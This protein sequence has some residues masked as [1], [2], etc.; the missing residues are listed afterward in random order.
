MFDLEKNYSTRKFL[1]LTWLLTERLTFCFE[2]YKKAFW[3]KSLLNVLTFFDLPGNSICLK[4]SFWSFDIFW[5]PRK[6]N[7][8]EEISSFLSSNFGGSW[9]EVLC[10]NVTGWIL[11]LPL[12]KHSEMLGS[13][14]LVLWWQIK[15][16][17]YNRALQQSCT[18]NGRQWRKRWCQ[19]KTR[20]VQSN[21]LSLNWLIS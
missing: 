5:S 8:K 18:W 11:Q 6:I 21:N 3:F 16:E 20:Y 19:R 12:Q 4:V 17:L 10:F 9:R 14:K 1:N 2:Y 15:Q 13:W 7:K